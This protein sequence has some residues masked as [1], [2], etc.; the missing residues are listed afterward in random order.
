MSYLFLSEGFCIGDKK[1]MHDCCLKDGSFRVGPAISHLSFTCLLGISNSYSMIRTNTCTSS[2]AAH[3]F[4]KY[5]TVK[6]WGPITVLQGSLEVGMW[7]APRCFSLD[8]G[9]LSLQRTPW[10]ILSFVNVLLRS[11]FSVEKMS[12]SFR[13]H[14]IHCEKIMF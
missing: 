12:L 4:L 9:F 14:L 5:V 1:N 3:C 8:P 2:C 11:G 10:N 7:E 13:A 6:Y